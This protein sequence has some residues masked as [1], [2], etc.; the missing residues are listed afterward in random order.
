MKQV[1]QARSGETSFEDVPS[2]ACNPGGVLVQNLFSAI[3]SGTERSTV[4]AAKQSLLARARAR[5]DL[6]RSVLTR[7][8]HEGVRAT[9][10]AVQ[11]T[12][13]A[14]STWIQLRRNGD[15]SGGVRVGHLPR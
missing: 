7:V 5:P 11:G 8:R 15:R 6:V 12:G 1:L 9:R 13:R 3:S 4:A 2:P 10:R 14:A